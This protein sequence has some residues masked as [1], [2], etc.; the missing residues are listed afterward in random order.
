VQA[1]LGGVGEVGGVGQL[2]ADD[3]HGRGHDL[4]AEAE[5]AAPRAL[6]ARH[7]VEVAISSA[8]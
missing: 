3:L 5:H 4:A 1:G 7:A 6:D 2:T 8:T